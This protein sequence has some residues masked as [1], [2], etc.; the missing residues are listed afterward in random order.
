MNLFYKVTAKKLFEIRNEIFVKNGLAALK[1]NGF[2]KLPFPESLFGKNNLGDYTYEL[3]RLNKNHHLE[4]ITTH[5]IKGEK[6]IQMYLNIVHPMPD[7]QSL[8]QLRNINGIQFQLPPNS[9]TKLRFR[10]GDFNGNPL[11][12]P[13]VLLQK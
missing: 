6:W 10:V 7:L 12:N 1:E 3:G 11:L 5:I 4:I 2:Q 9:L 13:V 8:D